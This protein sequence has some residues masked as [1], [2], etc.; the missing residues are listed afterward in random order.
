MDGDGEATALRRNDVRLAPGRRWTSPVSGAAY[1]VEWRVELPGR[2]A[3]LEV[4]AALDAQELDTAASTGVTYWEGAV[5]VTGR[6]GERPVR[7]RG[8]LEMTGYSGRPM[9]EVFR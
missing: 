6:V 2:Q 5:T 9:S 8:Y 7:G 4:T 1:P 3:T